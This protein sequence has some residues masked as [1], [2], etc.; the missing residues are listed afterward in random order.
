[1][2]AQGRLFMLTCKETTQLLSQRQDVPLVFRQQMD[3]RLHL[4]FCRSCRRFGQQVETLSQLSK[5]YK[6]HDAK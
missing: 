5:A 4:M 2:D 3:L 6:Q 1:M